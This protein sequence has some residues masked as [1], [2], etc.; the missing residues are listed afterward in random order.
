VLPL[1]ALEEVFS[2]RQ[3]ETQW[4]AFLSRNHLNEP[5]TL[6]EATRVIAAF[7]LPVLS[8]IADERPFGG[9]WQPGGPWSRG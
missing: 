5:E 2:D 9:H 7:S 8:A 3:R 4:R 6:R 1:I